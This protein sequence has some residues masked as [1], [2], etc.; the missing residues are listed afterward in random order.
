MSGS[1]PAPSNGLA[2][3][4]WEADPDEPPQEIAARNQRFECPACGW[5]AELERN[6]CMVC[7]HEQQLRPRGSGE[8]G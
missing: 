1:S 6:E 7:E 3:L 4:L 5:I 2:K 8:R